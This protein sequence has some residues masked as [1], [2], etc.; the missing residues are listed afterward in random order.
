MDKFITKSFEET[1]N[2]G[3]K[4]AAEILAHLPAGRQE[5]P[6]KHAVVLAL[7]GD[8]GAGKTTFLQGFAKGLG[9]EENVLSPTFII[10]KKFLVPQNVKLYKTRYKHF[11]HFDLYRLESEKDVE[12]LNF[13]EIIS[14]PENIVAIEW[15]EK[16][17]GILPETAVKITFTHLEENKRE[18]SFGTKK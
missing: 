13:K 6:A 16:I 14:N 5:N 15:P 9:I 4:F 8:L 2:A 1:Q 11:Y 7:T 12:F 10:M 17:A 18:I 3:Q